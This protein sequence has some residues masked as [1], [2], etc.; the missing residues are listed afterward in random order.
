V[1]STTEP[2]RRQA[3]QRVKSIAELVDKLKNEAG[4]I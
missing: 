1:L 2:P 4:V 3:G